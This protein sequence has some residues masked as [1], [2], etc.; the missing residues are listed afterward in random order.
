MIDEEFRPIFHLKPWTASQ[1]KVLAAIGTNE[2]K[3][4]SMIASQIVDIENLHNLSTGE[5]IDYSVDPKTVTLSIPKKILLSI[6]GELT[7]ISGI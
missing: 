4:I 2:D 7:R 5:I 3:A 6:L 1:L